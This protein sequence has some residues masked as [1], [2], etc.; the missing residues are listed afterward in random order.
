MLIFLTE[1]KECFSCDFKIHHWRNETIFLGIL[2][3]N[4]YQNLSFLKIY[5]LLQGTNSSGQCGLGFSSELVPVPKYTALPKPTD[6]EELFICG[7]G[8]HT[9]ILDAASHSIYGSGLNSSQQLSL[10]LP[11]SNLFIPFPD[12]SFAQS[13]S[14]VACG[15]DFSLFLSN[16]G[17]LYGCGSNKYKQITHL[18]NNEVILLPFS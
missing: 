9:I 2:F 1:S 5:F 3:K 10:K 4:Y 8:N 11:P 17:V 16:H 15:W 6:S 12:T 7:G 14:A 18:C 13:I